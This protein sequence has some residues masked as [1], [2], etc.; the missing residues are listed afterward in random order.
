MDCLVL[1][2]MVRIGWCVVVDKEFGL[3]GWIKFGRNGLIIIL[4]EM[5]LG[6]VM[7]VIF[8]L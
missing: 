6:V 3:F 7:K 1:F 8:C 2:V 5:F 4:F